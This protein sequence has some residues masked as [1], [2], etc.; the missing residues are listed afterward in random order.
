MPM[1]PTPAVQKSQLEN[2]ITKAIRKLGK[3]TVRVKLQ[4]RDG[5]NR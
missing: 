2:A 4:P 1:L 5:F 3:E